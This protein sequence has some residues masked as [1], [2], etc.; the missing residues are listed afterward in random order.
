[1]TMI[2]M[3]IPTP[4]MIL[5][6]MSFHL[7]LLHQGDLTIPVSASSRGRNDAEEKRG[8]HHICFLTL[9][10]PRRNP[11]AETARSSA[12]YATRTSRQISPLPHFEVPEFLV[13]LVPKH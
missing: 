9:L 12:I 11:C 1:M 2:K 5:H 6:F 8:T 4:T 3:Q 13:A 10:A 7:L